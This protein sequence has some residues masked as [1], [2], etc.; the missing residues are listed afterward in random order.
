[1]GF[2]LT[3][4][5][6]AAADPG[7]VEHHLKRQLYYLLN[8]HL[9]LLLYSNSGGVQYDGVS[10]NNKAL[11]YWSE[12][13]KLS[14]TR[15]LW[16]QLCVCEWEPMCVC[17]RE[18]E[19]HRKRHNDFSPCSIVLF[20]SL[21]SLSMCFGSAHAL[22]MWSQIKLEKTVD[23]TAQSLHICLMFLQRFMNQWLSS[24]CFIFLCHV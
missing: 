2:K 6:V 13:I 12:L 19:R 14:V 24:D 10:A 17:R 23:R 9:A 18:G 4:C 8:S 15:G 5:S 7:S 22:H 11:A 21:F 20:L 3:T 1:M 16:C